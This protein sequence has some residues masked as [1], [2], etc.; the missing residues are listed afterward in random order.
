MTKLSE[1][2]CALIRGNPFYRNTSFEKRAVET[3]DAL[4]GELAEAKHAFASSLADTVQLR[5]KL[6]AN[7]ACPSG[8]PMTW[9]VEGCDGD[10]SQPNCNG[11]PSYC[12]ICREKEAVV[13]AFA[14][15]ACARICSFCESGLSA[16]KDGNPIS[17]KWFHD[18]SG[19]PAIIECKASSIRALI[20]PTQTSAQQERK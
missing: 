9:W 15:K 18:T 6:A 10:C 14:E 3:I 11:T 1:N 20:T 2:D 5:A 16:I 7:P 4:R 13:A 19:I 8:H 12:T 17:D